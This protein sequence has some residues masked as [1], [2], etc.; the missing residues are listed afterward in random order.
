ME[1]LQQSAIL[2]TTFQTLK[3]AQSESSKRSMKNNYKRQ[4]NKIFKL[5]RPKSSPQRQD[6]SCFGENL[7]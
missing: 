3:K 6:D 4:R 7:I 1:I 5:N 2:R